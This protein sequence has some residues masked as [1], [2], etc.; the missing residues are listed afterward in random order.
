MVVLEFLL[1]VGML[2]LISSY[3]AVNVL[4]GPF[5]AGEAAIAKDHFYSNLYVQFLKSKGI[6]VPLLFKE[7]V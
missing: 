4:K 7:Y 3:Y 1:K 6:E 2:S 5:P